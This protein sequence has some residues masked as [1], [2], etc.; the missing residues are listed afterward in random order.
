M[1]ETLT[2]SS[3][4]HPTGDAT[5]S[6][7][8]ARDVGALT[9]PRITLM[10]GVVAAGAMGLAPGRMAGADAVLALMGIMMAVSGAGALNM[11]LERDVD[12]LMLRTAERPLPAGRLH[13]AW[14]L[15][16]GTL[17]SAAALPIL[18]LVASPLTA[19]LTAFSL[20]VYVFVYTPMKRT[21]PW[22]LAVGAVPGAMPALMGSTAVAGAV[23]GVGLALFGV[24]FLWQLPH[25][26]AIGIYR[27]RDYEA[28][29][30]KVVSAVWGLEWARAIM[31]ATT[32]MLVLLG[33]ALWPLGVGGPLYGACALGVGAWF[34]VITVRGARSATGVNAWARRA[35]LGS[36]VYLTVLFA[37]L[38]LDAVVG[39][40]LPGVTWL[41]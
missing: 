14:A 4:M 27:E 36:L 39:R 20:F 41:Q 29:G 35:F 18:W 34:F 15:A 11:L 12:A 10:S 22:S 5:S 25:F 37:A 6:L 26:V 2:A 30:H 32:A 19:A 38:G 31:V 3:A 24:V 33:V 16:V 21:S 9:K 17:L 7:S 40:V 13:P 8:T 28:A 1:S 23:E